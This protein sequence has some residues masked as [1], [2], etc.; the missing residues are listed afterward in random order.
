MAIEVNKVYKV[1]AG[2][3][4]FYRKVTAVNGDKATV[5]LSL[6]GK[7]FNP[8]TQTEI[9]VAELEGKRGRKPKADEPAGDDKPSISVLIEKIVRRIVKEELSGQDTKIKEL[10]TKVDG[11]LK[12][13]MAQVPELVDKRVKTLFK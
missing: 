6:D 3:R 10:E 2:D 12:A 9:D 7:T 8:A 4:T 13:A 11:K 1:T 5:I